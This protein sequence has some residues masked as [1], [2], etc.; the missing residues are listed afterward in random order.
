VKRTTHPRGTGG[1]LSR[2]PARRP[3]SRGNSRTV[4]HGLASADFRA[5]FRQ[6]RATIEARLAEADAQADPLDPHHL[7]GELRLDARRLLVLIG[8]L[9][10]RALEAAGDD[11][12]LAELADRLGRLSRSLARVRGVQVGLALRCAGLA[13]GGPPALPDDPAALKERLIKLLEGD[14]A[15]QEG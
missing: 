8:L 2:P 3:G 15:T 5:W 4:R 1:K 10:A 13:D 6:T 12:A 11:A 9:E 7:S 14:H